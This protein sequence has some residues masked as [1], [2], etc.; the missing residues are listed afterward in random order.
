MKKKWIIALCCVLGG[1]LV[2][3]VTILL[4]SYIVRQENWWADL[5]ATPTSYGSEW[6]S[7]DGSLSFG[8]FEKYDSYEQ[9]FADG[10]VVKGSGGDITKGFITIDGKTIP[11]Y[12]GVD[13]DRTMV[14]LL[15][16]KPYLPTESYEKL[17]I[18][19]AVDYEETDTNIII[20]FEVEKTT[21]FQEGQE[22][23][24]IYNR[25]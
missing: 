13:Y 3:T 5:P 8:T 21:Y 23:K 20:F 10:H 1:L 18:W 7:E 22:I 6:H 11:V 4:F 9:T 12:V 19:K 16:D 15:N 17:E 2:I 24:L 25:K 14:I